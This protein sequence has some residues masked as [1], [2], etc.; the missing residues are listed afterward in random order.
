MDNLLESNGFSHGTSF[1]RAVNQ[2]DLGHVG[3]P[4]RWGASA[5]IQR[6]NQDEGP[7]TISDQI[8]RAQC[9]GLAARGWD[10]WCRWS[11]NNW[12]HAKDTLDLLALEVTLGAGMAS[13][14]GLI[15]LTGGSS[16]APA[17][18]PPGS[19]I[20]QNPVSV[21]NPIGVIQAVQAMPASALAVRLVFKAS[22]KQGGN[23]PKLYTV[24]ATVTVAPRALP[25]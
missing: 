4:E 17:T 15:S 9:K 3:D 6:S 2:R 7:A 25:W 18:A 21:D 12:E 14:S 23:S 22:K 5:T 11:I 16:Y 13:A 24:N 20:V 19:F 1:A 8:I 10:L